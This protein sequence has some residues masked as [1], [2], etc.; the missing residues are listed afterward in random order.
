MKNRDDD[1]LDWTVTLAPP[2]DETPAASPPDGETPAPA[3][4]PSRAPHTHALRFSRWLWLTFGGVI[5]LSLLALW[6]Y[7]VWTKTRLEMAL[8]RAVALEEQAAQD[9]DRAAIEQLIAPGYAEWTA[10]RVGLALTG[11]AAPVPVPWLTPITVPAQIIAL[12]PVASDLVSAEVQR[13]YRTPEGDTVVFTTAQ[14]YQYQDGWKRVPPPEAEN[15]RKELNAEWLTATYA[16]QDEAVVSAVWP[17]LAQ[18]AQDICAAW[19]CPVDFVAR[20][21]FDGQPVTPLPAAIA[22]NPRLFAVL[23]ASGVN[24]LGPNQLAL[25]A[26]H[27]A[28]APGDAI[29]QAEYQHLTQQ[30]LLAYIAQQLAEENRSTADG[31]NAFTFALA[32]RLGAQLGLEAPEALK[33]SETDFPPNALEMFWRPTN[34]DSW[35]DA[36]HRQTVLRGALIML[37]ALL[38]DEPPAL[39]REL[40]RQLPAVQSPIDWLAQSLGLSSMAEVFLRF[41]AIS[42]K[43]HQIT[44]PAEAE[45]LAAVACEGGPALWLR[46]ETQ[47]TSFLSGLFPYAMFGVWNSASPWSPDGQRLTIF[48][49]GLAALD[50]Q[51]R[52]LTWLPLEGNGLPLAPTAWLSPTQLAYL[53]YDDRASDNVFVGLHFYDFA[54]PDQTFPTV[55]HVQGYVLSPRGDLAV[56]IRETQIVIQPALGGEP[57]AVFTGTTPVWSPD[58]GALVYVEHLT[59]QN[60]AG[61]REIGFRIQRFDLEP[62]PTPYTVQAGDTLWGLSLR[63]GVAMIDLIN[64]NHLASDELLEGQ[65]LLIPAPADPDFPY[66]THQLLS[67]EDFQLPQVSSQIE[68]AWSP[69]GNQIAV[70]I[71]PGETERR[72]VLMLTADGSGRELIYDAPEQTYISRLAFSADGQYLAY[73]LGGRTPAAVAVHDARSGRRILAQEGTDSYAWAP[74]GHK[75]ALLGNGQ[76]IITEVNQRG[77]GAQTIVQARS[78]FE[79]WWR[80]EE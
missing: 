27:H 30:M 37:N 32:A 11:L 23:A 39:E 22:P 7:S 59:T 53:T 70:S 20:V 15:E 79:F 13:S 2:P 47:P 60:S 36:A 50:M 54:H 44:L 56:I 49:G 17:V 29:A 67:S 75:L 19:E 43:Y 8:A 63:Y 46:G 9:R 71:V 62:R 38:E 52:A 26:P 33:I 64:F 16:P 65:V 66:T 25:P 40:F 12:H 72:Q 4:A 73:A 28:G 69:L 3:S 61:V 31:P 80:P 41:R 45:V 55:S 58:G 76:I 10:K 51:T 77:L 48:L 1:L 21:A 34:A 5:A 78:C 42:E 6:G 68:M 24:W 35:N 57:L 74:T 18:T 14:F